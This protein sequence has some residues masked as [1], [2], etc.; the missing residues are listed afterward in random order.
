MAKTIEAIADELGLSITTVRL[1]LLGKARQYRISAKTEARVREY[2]ELHGYEINHVARSLR[3]QRSDALAL[4]IPRLSNHFFAQLAELLE[5]R[6]RKAGLQLWISCCY[7]N[8]DT[9]QELIKQFRERNVDGLFLVP[10]NASMPALAAAQLKQRL[11]LLDR[12]FGGDDYAV[13]VTDNRQSGYQLAQRLHSFCAARGDNQPDFLL[14]AGNVGMPSIGQ[15]LAG[16]NAALDDLGLSQRREVHVAHNDFHEGEQAMGELIDSGQPLPKVLVCSSIPLFEGAM[17]ALK[18]R[19]GGA[20][21]NMVLATFDD[22]SMLDFL[23]N[24]MCSVRQDYA[25]MIEQAFS[26]MAQLISGEGQPARHI[27]SMRLVPRNMD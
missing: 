10:A 11:V 16:L 26:E 24:P 5:I 12:D 14:F 22:H 2:T 25:F 27:A 3:L 6:C 18:Q 7:D 21:E 4:I 8:P 13:V 1:V 15:R 20:P 19:L 23:R 17:Q 9:Q